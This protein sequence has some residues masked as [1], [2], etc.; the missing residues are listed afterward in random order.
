MAGIVNCGGETAFSGMI[1]ITVFHENLPL[2]SV[3][4][5]GKCGVQKELK[6]HVT[7][8]VEHDGLKL[9]FYRLLMYLM[10]MR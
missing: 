7:I 10:S 1:F 2:H 9:W 8:S 6:I 5:G 3:I 4:N